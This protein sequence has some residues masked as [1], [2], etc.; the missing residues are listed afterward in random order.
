[1]KKLFLLF[2]SFILILS[3]CSSEVSQNAEPEEILDIESVNDFTPL[4]ELSEEEISAIEIAETNLI[5]EEI[6]EEPEIEPE[7]DEEGES[8]EVAEEN[9]TQLSEDE[10]Q[11]LEGNGIEEV[12]PEFENQVFI[13]DNDVLPIFPEPEVPIEDE[14]DL[15]SPTNFVVGFQGSFN[16]NDIEEVLAFVDNPAT[17]EYF[18][19]PGRG[20]LGDGWAVEVTNGEE[21]LTGES[22]EGLS[23]FSFPRMVNFEDF[24]VAILTT[25]EGEEIRVE[26]Q[27]TFLE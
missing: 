6:E 7:V 2:G 3:A 17:G 26:I 12:A 1:M 14:G 9:L 22:F 13:P 5:E 4:E 19:A 18:V 27:P 20:L 21:T 23:T 10:F 15:I 24:N 11:V 25:P 8:T 16:Y